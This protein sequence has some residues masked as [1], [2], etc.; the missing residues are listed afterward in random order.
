MICSKADK[1]KRGKNRR[2]WGRNKKTKRGEERKKKNLESSIISTEGRVTEK[3][4][5]RQ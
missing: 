4:K 3:Q 5:Q 1:S 2:I